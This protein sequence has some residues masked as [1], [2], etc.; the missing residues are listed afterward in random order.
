MEALRVL[1]HATAQPIAGLPCRHCQSPNQSGATH[2]DLDTCVFVAG[3]LCWSPEH[4]S[5]VF[6]NTAPANFMPAF[7]CAA[8]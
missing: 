2:I 5:G 1:V 3:V 4:H 6:V 7:V 8:R